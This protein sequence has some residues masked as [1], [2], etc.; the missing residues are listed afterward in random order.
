MLSYSF[1]AVVPSLS[2][3][4]IAEVVQPTTVHRTT[5]EGV[6]Q[7]SKHLPQVQQQRPESP[8]VTPT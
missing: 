2:Q 8:T 7:H 6:N 3:S 1:L 5:H 4:F